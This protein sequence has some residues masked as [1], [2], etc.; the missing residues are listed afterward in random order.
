VLIVLL[1][2][3]VVLLLSW[4]SIVED[5]AIFSGMGAILFSRPGDGSVL[6]LLLLLPKSLVVVTDTNLMQ[7]W[8]ATKCGLITDNR[9]FAVGDGGRPNNRL[10]N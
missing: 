6:L 9:L 2:G 7:L 3:S 5:E 10:D 8:G 1:V 4:I